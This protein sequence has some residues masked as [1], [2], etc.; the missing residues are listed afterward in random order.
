MDDC[1]YLY[2]RAKAPRRERLSVEGE[3]LDWVEYIDHDS[4]L[5]RITP[6]AAMR[7]FESQRRDIPSA[8]KQLVEPAAVSRANPLHENAIAQAGS[9]TT[10]RQ[11]AILNILSKLTNGTGLEGKEIA[12]QLPDAHRRSASTLR[13]H[14]FPALLKAGLIVNTAGIGYHLPGKSD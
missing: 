11:Q 14:D 8:V 3:R 13:R 12:A 6:Q 5:K 1:A 4:V 9:K 10:P 2:E 7:W